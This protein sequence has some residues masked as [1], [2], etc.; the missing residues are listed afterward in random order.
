MGSADEEG[1]VAMHAPGSPANLVGKGRLG[2]GERVG[3]GHLEDRRD[4]SHHRGAGA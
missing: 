3:V 4:A 1:E 2:D